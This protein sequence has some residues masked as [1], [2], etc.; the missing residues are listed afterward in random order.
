VLDVAG[1]AGE[2]QKRLP[3][4]KPPTPRGPATT[5]ATATAPTLRHASRLELGRQEWLIGA[6]TLLLDFAVWLACY[7]AF[8]VLRVDKYVVLSERHWYLLMEAPFL[9]IC[10]VFFTIGA[11]DK[12]TNVL[13]LSYMS[14]H[15]IAGGIAALLGFVFVYS[16]GAYSESIKPSR[17]V[18]MLSFAVFTPLSLLYRRA[19][20]GRVLAH[21]SRQE[22]LVL[23]AGKMAQRFFR[24]YLDS[25]NRQRLR[26]VNLNPDYVNAPA[27]LA[28]DLPM[29][30]KDVFAALQALGPNDEGVIIAE[31]TDRLSARLLERLVEVHFRQVPVYSLEA[32][33]E[34]YW[35][36]I[37]VTA[38]EPDWP[39]RIG[40]QL[41][42]QSPYAHVKRLF[43]IAVSGVALLLLSPLL[44]GLVVLTWIDSGGPALFRQTRVGLGNE[45]FTILKF[46]TMHSRAAGHEGDIY[47]SVGDVRITRTGRWL[48]K[49]RLDELPQ[50][51]NVFKGDMTLIG[52]RAE[53]IR[54]AALYQGK[55]PFYH[56]RHL[57]KPGITGW[58]QINYPYGA[59]AEDALQ[60]LKYDLYYIRNY[61]LRLDAMIVLK[62]LHI[63]LWGKGQ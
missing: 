21:K 38:L 42:S 18:L 37:P 11:Y 2:H 10:I 24:T 36:K 55:I 39:L 3:P 9:A 52:P 28:E 5:A 45:P 27:F 59:S 20:W 17:S 34:K 14:E 54:C 46:R 30:D 51:W 22:F 19:I 25:P 43:D 7:G 47:T 50:L 41:V 16:I 53:W 60:K 58:A 48:R 49:L 26:F 1:A 31:K 23:G 33:Y 13:S 35:R 8:A 12:R 61:S 15:F 40:F 57:V 29:V 44:A 6:A 63:M 32:F 56:V 62:T 4:M